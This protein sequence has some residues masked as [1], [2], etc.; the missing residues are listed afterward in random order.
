[1]LMTL[2]KKFPV[3]VR[4]IVKDLFP[5]VKEVDME[6]IQTSNELYKRRW[7]QKQKEL[8]NC[9][10]CGRPAVEGETLCSQHKQDNKDRH[11]KWVAKTDEEVDD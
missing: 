3:A 7:R 10:E 6:E 11:A 9:V 4:N 2:V 1:M 5:P 8:G